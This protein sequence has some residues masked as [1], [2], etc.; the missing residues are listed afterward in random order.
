MRSFCSRLVSSGAGRTAG[1]R[2]KL[3][4]TASAIDFTASRIVAVDR[5]CASFA[6]LHTHLMPLAPG[7]HAVGRIETEDVLRAELV[8]DVAVDRAELRR[9]LDRV[10]V[11]ARLAAELP[12]LVLHVDV[13]R[14]HPDPDGVDRHRRAAG[15]LD[16][17]IE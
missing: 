5:L 13:G 7:L 12:E 4:R 15:V 1:A 17:L 6:D 2:Q 8:L 16:R 10:E 11:P 14:T 3:T 9:V